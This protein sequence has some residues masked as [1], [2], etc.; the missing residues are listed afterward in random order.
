MTR[1]LFFVAALLA[2]VGCRTAPVTRELAPPP[3]EPTAFV[4][5]AARITDQTIAA[6]SRYLDLLTQRASASP[7]PAAARAW[8][9]VAR[10]EYTATSRDPFVDFAAA[11]ATAVAA[12]ATAG[13]AQHAWIAHRRTTRGFRAA[14]PLIR[15]FSLA[16]AAPA[17]ADARPP[18]L[19]AAL[20]ALQNRLAKL[21]DAGVPVNS[22]AWAK[23]QAWL[24]F[25]IDEHH[26]RD[27]SGIVAAASRQAE[28]ILDRLEA[29][30]DREPGRS[31]AYPADSDH[32][33]AAFALARP[34]L[35]RSSRLRADLWALAE[36]ARPDELSTRLTTVDPRLATLA[37]LE[38]AL[39]HAAHEH[40]QRGW[41]PARSYFLAAERL[42]RELSVVPSP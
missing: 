5:V 19:T 14:L 25:A 40:G 38:V 12:T 15:Q 30:L 2:L 6:D 22:Y 42:A 9:L 23:A 17:P 32:T 29:S 36:S 37:Q 18:H 10:A 16:T 24:D 11:Q 21:H 26:L 28:Q 7:A 34:F 20:F 8:L 1:A 35:G 13:E 33:L 39:I 41:R 3:P 27:A 31:V 4:P